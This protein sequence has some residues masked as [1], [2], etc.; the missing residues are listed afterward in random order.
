M[1]ILLRH[2]PLPGIDALLE[3]FL[4]PSRAGAERPAAPRAIRVDVRETAD[5]YVVQADL[6]G[7]KKDEIGIEVEGDE[8]VLA[9]ETRREEL[10]QDAGRWLHLE[11]PLGKL[12][13]RFS[14]PQ[15]LDGTR[16]DARFADGVLTLTLPKKAPTASRRIEVR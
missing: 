4:R 11:R 5:A 1:N 15:E 7:V 8:V 14:L 16:A 2:E 9:A 10:A 3:P 6:P 12:E 13:R